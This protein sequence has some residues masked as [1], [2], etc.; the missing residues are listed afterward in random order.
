MQY[1]E[2]YVIGTLLAVAALVF[3]LGGWSQRRHLRRLTQDLARWRRCKE[4]WGIRVVP[5][6]GKSGCSA[7][8][9]MQHRILPIGTAPPLPL[10][11]CGGSR[12]RCRYH[13]FPERRRAQRRHSGIRRDTIR[14]TP[15]EKERREQHDRRK[16]D[17]IWEEVKH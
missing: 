13:P 3:V 5:G 9:D 8:R 14:F 2:L 6:K 15:A 4:Y 10:V 12:C 11:R 16:C 1:V 7:A 17:R